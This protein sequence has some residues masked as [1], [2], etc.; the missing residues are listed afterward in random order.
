MLDSS[1]DEAL[2]GVSTPDAVQELS[3][4]EG[5]IILEEEVEIDQWGPSQ[6]LVLW[7]D[8]GKPV[9][10]TPKVICFIWLLF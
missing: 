8:L 5:D 9:E 3:D 7:E 6:A 4:A 1:A 10:I 2:F